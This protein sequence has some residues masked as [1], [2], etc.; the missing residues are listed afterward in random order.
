[1][2]RRSPGFT[3]YLERDIDDACIVILSNNYAP[4][5]HAMI[6]GPAAILF[7]EAYKR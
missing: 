2:T 5:P 3:S 6:Q 4:A 7:G 1:V